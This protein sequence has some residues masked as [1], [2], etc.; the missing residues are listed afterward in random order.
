MACEESG[1]PARRHLAIG[2]D[3]RSLRPRRPLSPRCRI[4]L[5]IQQTIGIYSGSDLVSTL[6]KKCPELT[7]ADSGIAREVSRIAV[8]DR[9]SHATLSPPPR[10]SLVR[11]VLDMEEPAQRRQGEIYID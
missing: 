4:N 6:R 9:D 11:I 10:K 5:L 8:I 2:R 1:R 7:F 3:V